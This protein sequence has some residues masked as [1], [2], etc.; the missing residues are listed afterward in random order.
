MTEGMVNDEL[1]SAM[2]NPATQ[3]MFRAGLLACRE[4]M[5]S[6]VESENPAI[7]ASIRA[8]WWPSLGDDPGKP[9]RLHWNDV[10][11]GEYP[12]GRPKTKEEVSPSV[13]A[14]VQAA[15]FLQRHC[16]YS[17]ARLGEPELDSQADGGSEHG[18]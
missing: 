4:Y 5:A 13:E 18:T 12:D 6:F 7:A 11:L 15:I 17:W 14:L 10:Y 9:R 1:Q 16:G 3:V 2:L 8:N